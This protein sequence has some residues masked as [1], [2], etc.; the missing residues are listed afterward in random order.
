MKLIEITKTA[1]ILSCILSINSSVI[2]DVSWG[3]ILW[4]TIIKYIKYFFNSFI[5]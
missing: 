3:L 5:Q 1:E 4:D 2:I